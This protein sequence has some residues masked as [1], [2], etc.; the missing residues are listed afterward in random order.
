ML[1]RSVEG[2][3]PNETWSS[4]SET[5]RKYSLEGTNMKGPLTRPHN[6]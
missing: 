1:M 5:V 3:P 6:H 2:F 4:K